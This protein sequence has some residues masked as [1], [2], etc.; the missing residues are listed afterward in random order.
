LRSASSFFLTTTG[1]CRLPSKRSGWHTSLYF[2]YTVHREKLQR[3][4][5]LL[6]SRRAPLNSDFGTAPIARRV[7][8]S[9]RGELRC[10]EGG[11]L[12]NPESQIQRWA[13]EIHD[14]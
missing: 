7:M 4:S 11:E 6:G 5:K 3:K 13:A 8:P 2:D 10:S 1:A 9:G 14:W 12:N